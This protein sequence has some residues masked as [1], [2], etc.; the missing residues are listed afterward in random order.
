VLVEGLRPFCGRSKLNREMTFR[1]NFGALL[2]PEAV[3]MGAVQARL[4]QFQD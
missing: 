4:R 2:L 3:Q 1:L